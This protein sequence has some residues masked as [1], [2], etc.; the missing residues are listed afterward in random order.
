M[1]TSVLGG[2]FEHM[3]WRTV[4]VWCVDL[5]VP[6]ERRA[7]RLLSLPATCTPIT[8]IVPCPL[9][10]LPDTLRAVCVV[11]FELWIVVAGRVFLAV[12]LFGDQVSGRPRRGHATT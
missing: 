4:G 6:M 5:P 1:Q 11:V 3:F 10:V 8:L 9:P 12:L 2:V 7:T